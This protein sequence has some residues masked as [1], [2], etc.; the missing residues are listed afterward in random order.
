MFVQELRPQRFKDV[1]GQELPKAMLQAIVKN[2]ANAPRTIILEGEYGTGKTTTARI[3]AKALNCMSDHKGKTGDACGFCNICKSDMNHSVFYQEYDSAM[4]GNVADIRQLRETFYFDKSIGYKVIVIDECHL[5]S[6]AGQGALLKVFEEAQQGIFFLLCTTNAEKLLPTIKSR[7]LS[8]KYE[9]IPETNI[10]ENIK[11]VLEQKKIT[12][13]DSSIKRVIQGSRGHMRNAHMLLDQCIMLGEEQFEKLIQSSEELYYKLIYAML[14]NKKD[15]VIKLLDKLSR[16]TL[17][18]LKEDYE[19]VVLKLIKSILR[20]EEPT[21]VCI[22][23]I[24]KEM[25]TKQIFYINVLNN[26]DNFGMFTSEK[27]F[28]ACMW[29]LY[30][31]LQDIR[32]K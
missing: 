20:I 4:M 7:S 21:D 17:T 29:L 12:L 22:S 19:K 14:L 27:R 25:S 15:I 13:S 5:I 28:E 16:F 32:N 30:K 3:F 26:K 8:L 9:L 23:N 10:E 18:V 2:P 31:G 11:S 6:A 24:C 1:A